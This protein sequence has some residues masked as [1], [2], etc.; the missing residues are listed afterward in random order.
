[1]HLALL[2]RL[3]LTDTAEASGQGCQAHLNAA[4]IYIGRG[5]PISEDYPC[6]IDAS[7]GFYVSQ[8]WLKAS[9]RDTNTSLARVNAPALEISNDTPSYCVTITAGTANPLLYIKGL[10]SCPY[11]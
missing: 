4:L 9:S 8:N 7:S 1:M 2:R 5:E 11:C 3:A 10:D 6:R